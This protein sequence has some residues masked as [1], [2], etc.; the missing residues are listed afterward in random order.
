[1]RILEI[2]EQP[3]TTFPYLNVGGGSRTRNGLK[4]VF[5]AQLPIYIAYVDEI[6]SGLD[7]LIVAS[8]LQGNIRTKDEIILL[9][10]VLPAFLA[11]FIEKEIKTISPEFTGV[12]L[13]GDMYATLMKRGGLGDVRN[14]WFAFRE[15]FKWVAGVA[16][17]HDDYG[18]FQGKIE[19]KLKEKDIYF[20]E[21]E[22]V[23]IDE[24]K[25]GGVSGIIGNKKK[26]FRVPEEEYLDHI[27]NRLIKKPDVLLIHPSPSYQEE[28]LIGSPEIRETLESSYI[29]T[30][31][32]SGHCHW[33]KH[34]V[35]LK[36]GTQVL[37]ADAKVFILIKK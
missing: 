12:M 4:P 7:A 8:D 29:P 28:N 33:K 34:L 21:K 14:V 31:V 15:H 36:N 13:C 26:L 2:I 11:E 6:P 1:M 22:S 16:G 9:G 19:F 5:Q 32:C 37:N 18:G 23:E 24:L 30:L 17:N 27:L 25:I 3:I 35:E 20:L 10:E